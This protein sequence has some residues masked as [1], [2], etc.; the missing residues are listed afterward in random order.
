MAYVNQS[1]TP[2]RC[3]HNVHGR[4]EFVCGGRRCL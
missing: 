3:Q 1:V 2:R 4:V